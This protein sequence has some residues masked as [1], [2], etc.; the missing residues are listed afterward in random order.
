MVLG[1]WLVN[2]LRP[3]FICIHCWWILEWPNHEMSLHRSA[4][5]VNLVNDYILVSFDLRYMLV[6]DF[7]IGYTLIWLNVILNKVVIK[8]IIGYNLKCMRDTYSQNEIFFL[9]VRV[10]Y[11][12]APRWKWMDNYMVVSKLYWQ[13]INDNLVISFDFLDRET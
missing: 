9:Y 10:W 6:S 3:K 12:W 8:A 1:C 11:H 5:I 7:M 4:S 13:L 2:L